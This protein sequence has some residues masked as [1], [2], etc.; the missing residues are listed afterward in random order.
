[1]KKNSMPRDMLVVLKLTTGVSDFNLDFSQSI[2]A[3]KIWANKLITELYPRKVHARVEVR[4]ARVQFV[5]VLTQR[6][7]SNASEK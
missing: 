4:S 6:A 2:R 1:M 5:Q 3:S 7:N